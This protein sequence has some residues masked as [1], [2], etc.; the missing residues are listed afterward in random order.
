MIIIGTLIASLYNF[1]PRDETAQF[2]QRFNILQGISLCVTVATSML[3]TFTIGAHIY[4][5]TFRNRQAW[6]RYKHLVEIIIQSSALY[7]VSF[8][9][10]AIIDLIGTN[11]ISSAS[12]TILLNANCYTSAISSFTAVYFLNFFCF[13]VF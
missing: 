10:T 6:G 7:S 2:M 9:V 3:T 4:A 5:S 13:H 12:P 8:L 11:G 1:D